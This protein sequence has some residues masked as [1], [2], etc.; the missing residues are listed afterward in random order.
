MIKQ[1]KW[2]VCKRERLATCRDYGR[3][4]DTPQTGVSSLLNA[5]PA[6]G[7]SKSQEIKHL[8]APVKQQQEAIK[9]LTSPKSPTRE[10]KAMTSHSV[11]WLDIM[12]DKLFKLIPGT[13]N[14]R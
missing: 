10:P 8:S 7:G 12:R 5:P 1:I 2:L 9:Q 4:N 3:G 6:G 13:V 11:S 14:K